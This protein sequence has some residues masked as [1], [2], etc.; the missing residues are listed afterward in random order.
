MQ[1]PYIPKQVTQVEIVN[2]NLSES[3]ALRAVYLTLKHGMVCLVIF[4]PY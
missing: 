1:P 4:R 2:K 3:L